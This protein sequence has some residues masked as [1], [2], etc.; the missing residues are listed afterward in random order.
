[1]RM[2]KYVVGS[3]AVLLFITSAL[4]QS[5][6]RSAKYKIV[7]WGMN[8]GELRV[9]EKTE[10]GD[11]SIEVITDV[12]VKMI[13][14]YHV[15]YLQQS[16]F[17]NGMLWSSHVKT[18]KNGKINSDTHIE[19]QGENYLLIQDGDSSFVKGNINYSGSLLYF[20]EPVKSTSIYNERNGEK[21]VV[22]SVHE[23]TYVLLDKKGHKTNVYEYEDGELIHAELI[24]FL[25]T[26]RLQYSP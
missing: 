4:A 23:H 5:S 2:G 12:Y 22:R 21:N 19:K 11:L 14:T 8:I 25:A 24:H 10:N 16:L 1:M 18:L 17:R 7:V 26:I 20:H 9:T 3:L 6:E 15:N 13:V